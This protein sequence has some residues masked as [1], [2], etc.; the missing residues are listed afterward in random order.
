MKNLV[1]GSATGY[2][3]KQIFNFIKSL[4]NCYT[5]DVYLIVNNNIDTEIID[6]F[7]EN[8]INKITTDIKGKKIQKERYKIYLDFISKSNYTNILISDVKDVIFQ[9][10]PF[11]NENFNEL[12]FFFEDNI[13]G[14]CEHN[15]RWIKKLYGKKIFDELKNKQISC[16]GT[17]LGVKEE[18]MKYLRRMIYH[19]FNFKYFS[20]FNHGYDQGWHNYIIYKEKTLKFKKFCNQ[21]GFIATLAQSNVENF[22]FS[23]VL[24]TKS[25]KKFDIIH[26]Y[27]RK[28]FISLM[29]KILK[30]LVN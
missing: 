17:T 29:S 14:N 3:K 20:V 5:E 4:R 15:S 25:G 26:Q 22:I 11:N 8:K 27:D 16:S 6:F 18:M 12:N 2:T 23:D 9:N 7:K 24:K 1:L 21:D 13:I 19:R 30:N 28:R 10:N